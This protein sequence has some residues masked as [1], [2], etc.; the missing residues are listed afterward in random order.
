MG[1]EFVRDDEGTYRNAGQGKLNAGNKPKILFNPI[2]VKNTQKSESFC[3]RKV[4]NEYLG[5]DI[6]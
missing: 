4:K 1:R 5:N 6:F 3:D 2:E